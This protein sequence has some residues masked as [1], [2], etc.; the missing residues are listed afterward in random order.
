MDSLALESGRGQAGRMPLGIA[1]AGSAVVA[2]LLPAGRTGHLA[3]GLPQALRL[4]RRLGAHNIHYGNRSWIP[5]DQKHWR[6]LAGR[7]RRGTHVSGQIS[8]S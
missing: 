5:W 8:I 6:E 3:A 7:D 4:P 1:A 2:D